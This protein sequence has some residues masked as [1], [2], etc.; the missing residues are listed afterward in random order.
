M[1][2][3]QQT[4]FPPPFSPQFGRLNFWW[5]KE[6]TPLDSKGCFSVKS[7]YYALNP[8]PPSIYPQNVCW[9]KL[10]KQKAPERIKVF[11]WRVG[12]NTL[13]TRK[14]ISSQL[15]LRTRSVF[16]VITILRTIATFSSNAQWPNLYG[17][18]HVGDLNQM[19]RRSL[20]WRTSSTL[21]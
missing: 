4:P 19:S 10:W 18:P 5:A 3:F 1:G 12:I 8:L 17:L 20:P 14:N 16:S 2:N 7:A 13:P 11:L 21:F 15:A 9:R 6:K